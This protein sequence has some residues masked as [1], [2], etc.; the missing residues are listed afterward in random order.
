MT[1]V[2][3]IQLNEIEPDKVQKSN[4]FHIN[5]LPKNKKNTNYGRD[6]R[7]I[8]AHFRNHRFLELMTLIENEFI[9]FEN[10]D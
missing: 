3:V 4:Y 9:T 6:E 10:H 5:V 2:N 7:D 8:K 1:I